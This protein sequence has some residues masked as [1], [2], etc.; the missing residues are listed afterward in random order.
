MK[1]IFIFTLLIILNLSIANKV[2]AATVDIVPSKNLVGIG[3][4]FYVDVMVAMESGE[5]VN[6]ISGSISFSN[7]NISFLRAEEGKS[8]INLWVEKPK[9]VDRSINFAG[10]I[11]NGFSGVI[12][13]FNPD[14]K[15]PGLVI[16]LIF[17]P[18][19][20]G[21]VSFSTSKFSLNLND[22]LG[23]EIFAEPSNAYVDVGDFNDRL[24]LINN[25]DVEPKLE[26]SVT[27]D[28]NIF[29]NKFF[30]IFNATDKESGIKNVRIKEGRRDWKEIES[31]YLLLDQS[32]HSSISLQAV[33]FS[34]AGVSLNIDKIPYNWVSLI[35][36]V[37]IA[38]IIVGVIGLIVRKIYVYKHKN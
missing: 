33:N 34:G 24:V 32:R 25:Q 16:R 6:A 7:D 8:I 4:Q 3:E 14:K 31:P 29:N 15:L 20:S 22:G 17:E 12:N 21:N 38:I 36:I 9:S 5:S 35:K 19:N 1:K 28:P 2:F 18:K 27:K 37:I 13:P 26:A 30:L 10:V 11:S 23:T